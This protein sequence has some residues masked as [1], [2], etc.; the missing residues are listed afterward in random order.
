MLHKPAFDEDVGE[1]FA[2]KYRTQ[3]GV[4]LFIIYA[5]VYVTFVVINLVSPISMEKIVL[6]GLNLA[7]VYGMGLILL[8]I[9]LALIYNRLCAEKEREFTD[10]SSRMERK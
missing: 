10:S 7:I 4:R 5:I 1:D 9:L 8:A 2:L 6:W 3:I